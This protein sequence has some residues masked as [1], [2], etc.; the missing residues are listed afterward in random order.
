MFSQGY[1]PLIKG[2]HI[3]TPVQITVGQSEDH[4]LG[5]GN[6][7]CDRNIIPV[8]HTG[9]REDVRFIRAVHDRVVK[10]DHQIEIITFDHIDELLFPADTSGQKF[11]NFEV[12]YFLDPAAGHLCC[13]E[14]VLRKDVFI[15]KTKVLDQTFFAVMSYEADIHT[16]DLLTL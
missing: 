1:A 6:V 2:M 16:S 3:F 13:I 15:S 5:S 10:K 7:G 8:A 9:D 11:M 14:L 12:R 4:G